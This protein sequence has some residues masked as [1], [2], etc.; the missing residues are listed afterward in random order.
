MKQYKLIIKSNVT[1]DI[2]FVPYD[3]ITIV[4]ELNKGVSG[5]YNVSYP[6]LK[7]YAEA[8]GTTPDAIF[9]T[10]AREWY[11]E[12]SG[13]NLYG[14]IFQKRTMMGAGTGMTQFSV[15]LLDFSGLL[16]KRNT[17]ALFQRL[18]TDSAEIVSDLLTATNA[19]DDTGI[20]MGAYPTTKDRD[21]TS[22]YE[23][24][25]DEIISMSNLKKNE[26]YDWEVD[27]SKKLNI[28]YPSRGTALPDLMFNEFNT[29]NIQLVKPLQGDLTNKVYVLGEG[30]DTD[31]VTATREET[32]VQST[33][34]LLEDI[35]SE[36]G[37]GTTVNLEDRGDQFLADNAFPVDTIR[38]EHV[39]GT[40]NIESYRVGDTV[41]LKFGEISLD[42]N[43]RIYRRQIKISTKGN[44]VVSLFFEE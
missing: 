25:R 34:G 36:K 6:D 10:G 28:F 7:K 38:V 37:I 33:W 35:T 20:V 5:T 14:G 19:E 41:R 23:K 3:S 32:S 40:P 24:I 9:S 29:T 17:G 15:N 26:G 16:N 11:L 42:T 4:E 8:L 13:D 43:L 44:A 21:L 30:Y 39:D 31:M 2:F 22:R 27:V 1:D 12:V 18:A